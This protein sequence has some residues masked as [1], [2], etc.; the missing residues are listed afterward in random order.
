MVAID[1]IDRDTQE[2]HRKHLAGVFV[3]I[4]LVP[5]SE[6]VRGVVEQTPYG[7]I[8]IDEKGQTSEPGIFAC[9]DVTTVPYKQI[10]IAMG[11]NLNFTFKILT[12]FLALLA[13]WFL[14]LLAAVG[15]QCCSGW[16][17]PLVLELVGLGG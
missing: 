12:P 15:E 8:V 14:V 16:V 2:V 11:N 7:E 17:L 10:V 9:G 5:N 13:L 6:F 1:Y 4:G 3:Q